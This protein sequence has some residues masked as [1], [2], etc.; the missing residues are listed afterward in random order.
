MRRVLLLVGASLALPTIASAD[1]RYL[2]LNE[3]LDQPVREQRAEPIA[4]PA[5]GAA[6]GGT[7]TVVMNGGQRGT[8]EV[9]RGEGGRI[10]ISGAGARAAGLGFGPGQ[11]VPQADYFYAIDDLRPAVS[12]R[13]QNGELILQTGVDT[14]AQRTPGIQRA[15]RQPAVQPIREPVA[16]RQPPALY[17]D[18]PVTLPLDDTTRTFTAAAAPQPLPVPST[19]PATM[20]RSLPWPSVL[21]QTPPPPPAPRDTADLD[22]VRVTVDGESRGVAI[23]RIGPRGLPHFAVEDLATMRIDVPDDASPAYL[24][25]PDDLAEA[26]TYRYD[27]TAS[28]LDLE[29]VR[30]RRGWFDWLSADAGDESGCQTQRFKRGHTHRA[31]TDGDC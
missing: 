1:W 6:N 17:P 16:Q 24:L 26:Y 18:G 9:I 31:R 14:A 21:S 13:I 8:A 10:L 28:Q 30:S 2:I 4:A 23:A 22:E 20:P 19:P 25:S 3:P 29:R 15:E 12:A 11:G 7:L 27:A 5:N